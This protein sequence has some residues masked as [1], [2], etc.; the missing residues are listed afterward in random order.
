MEAGF[1]ALYGWLD[2]G[3]RLEH[4]IRYHGRTSTFPRRE[5][6]PIGGQ[7]R[8]PNGSIAPAVPARIQQPRGEAEA[9]AAVS[10]LSVGLRVF[11]LTIVLF[12][13][14]AAASGIVGL[15]NAQPANPD[16]SA[17]LKLFLVCVLEAAMMANL[18]LRSR[19][20]G[21][22]LVA[23]VF[24]V[25]YAVTTFMPQIESAVFLTHLP[26][27]TVPRLFLMGVLIAA[28][29]S[30][31]A[32]AFLG[33]WKARPETLESTSRLDLPAGEWVR[34]LGVIAIAYVILYFTFGYFIAWR[35]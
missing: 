4:G 26:P 18:I 22:R 27:G 17:A 2:Q 19:W 20:T 23:A 7:R 15:A 24:V 6:L 8:L 34:K 14:I 3:L 30:L 16:S 1:P 11:A 9:G 28:P 10:V 21:W 12:V 25:F 32:V 33:K 31:F 35:N 5:I 29:F 13:C